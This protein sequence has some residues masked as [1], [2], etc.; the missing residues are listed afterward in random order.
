MLSGDH[1]R[2]SHSKHDQSPPCIQVYHRTWNLSLYPRAH[3]RICWNS[4]YSE[5]VGDWPDGGDRK[6]RQ[7][8]RSQVVMAVFCLHPQVSNGRRW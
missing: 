3:R 4:W 6:G 8:W 5:L 2:F 7:F 1:W